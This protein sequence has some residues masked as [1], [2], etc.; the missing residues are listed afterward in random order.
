LARLNQ[1]HLLPDF[2]LIVNR[3]S[4]RAVLENADDFALVIWG[5]ALN[6]EE[7]IPEYPKNFHVGFYQ[8]DEDTV[9]AVYKKLK[10]ADGLTFESEPKKI[11]DTFGFYFR[12]ESL[13]I[14]ISINPFKQNIA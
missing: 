6:N 14:E 9:R 4:K 3:H 5:Q 1:S 12:F 8:Q 7:S 11:R 10:D 2:T 13:I